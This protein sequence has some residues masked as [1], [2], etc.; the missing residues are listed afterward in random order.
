MRKGTNFLLKIILGIAGINTFTAC[1][2]TVPQDFSRLEPYTLSGKVTDESGVP[3]GGVRVTRFGT[4]LAI[5]SEDGRFE[6]E[7]LRS[8]Y[9]KSDTLQIHFHA[10]SFNEQMQAV[11]VQSSGSLNVVLK[12]K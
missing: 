9:Q 8:P 3:L 12:K 2:G 6:V 7:F 4:D 5:T 10:A 1:Y 11:N